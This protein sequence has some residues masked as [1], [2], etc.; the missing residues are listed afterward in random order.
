MR[1]FFD[2]LRYILLGFIFISAAYLYFTSFHVGAQQFVWQAQSF[3]SGKMDIVGVRHVD[4]AQYGGKLYWPQGP[5]PSVILLPFIFVFGRGVAQG[6]VQALIIIFLIYIVIRTARRKGYSLADSVYLCSALLLGSVFVGILTQPTSW[7]F[8]QMIAALLLCIMLYE[9]EYRRR[10]FLL[11]CLEGAIIATRPTASLFGL[12]IVFMLVSDLFHRRN[13]LA[14]SVSFIIPI[15]GTLICLAWF[16]WIRFGSAFD[17]GYFTNNIG[18]LVDPL[19]S[20]GLFSYRHIPMNIYWYFLSG[21]RPVTDGTQHIVFPFFRYNDWG[22]TMF[23]VSPFFLY[24]FRTFGLGIGYIR[25]LW[26][27]VGCTLLFLLM[28]Y[29][30]GW[31]SFGPRYVA[32]FMPILYILLLNAFPN[33]TLSS[34]H[35]NM[36][37]A[38]AIVNVYILYATRIF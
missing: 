10:Y 16:N 20:M 36:I 24:T 17:N 7:Y 22:F 6:H 23:F 18:P 30:T 4:M 34:T 5:F 37:I 15:A 33:R 8:S 19:R 26:M 3:L 9:W 29:S 2:Y 27:I 32:D 35:K 25:G 11:G 31:V 38:S 14:R 28:Y 1:K 21:L 12:Y 13:V